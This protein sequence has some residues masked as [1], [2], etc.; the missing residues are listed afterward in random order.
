MAADLF[1][2]LVAPERV[3]DVWP[4]VAPQIAKYLRAGRLTEGDVKGFVKAGKWQLWIGWTPDYDAR[5]VCTTDVFEYP[6]GTKILR[7]NGLGGA[8]LA[9]AKDCFNL[10]LEWGRH[11]GCSTAEIWGRKGF[12]RVF[13]DWEPKQVLLEKSL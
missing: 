6:G 3:D 13:P 2:M 1:P 12:E 10:I 5:L 11:N 7:F 4:K 9:D 8:D